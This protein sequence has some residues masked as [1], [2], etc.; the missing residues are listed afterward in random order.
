MTILDNIKEIKKL[1]KSN[2]LGSVQQLGLQLKQT[3]KELKDLQIPQNYQNI[4]NIVVNGMGG[5]RLGARVAQRLF[6]DRLKVPIYPIGSYQLPA[7]VNNKTLLIISSYSGNTEEP[8][9]TVNQAFKRK[10]K[11]LVFSQNGRLTK[12]AKQKKLPGYYGFVPKHNPCN[13]PRMS[14]G[15]QV[16]GIILLLDKCK[17]LKIPSSEINQLPEFIEQV[18]NKYDANLPLKENL[19]KQVAKEIQQKIPL[20][21]GAEFI[22]GALHVWKNQTNENAKQLAVKFEIPEL[23]HH[24]LEGMKFPENNPNNLAFVFVKSDLYQPRNQERIEITKKVLDGYKIKHKEI[25]LQGKNKLSQVFEI[26]QFGSFVG[27][28]LSMLNKLDPS[29]IPW[30]DYFK[31]ELKKL[32]PA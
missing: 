12:I 18:K 4:N 30:V 11:I 31:K 20:L 14:L 27:F 15:Y 22:M 25:K 32:N 5:S 3:R 24:L 1:D 2:L 23:N 13:Q 6:E 19:A 28:Y 29:L 9:K 17:L 10:A 26:I 8:L 7:F 16:L 21:V